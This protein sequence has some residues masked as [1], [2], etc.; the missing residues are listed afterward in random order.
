MYAPFGYVI[1]GMNIMEQL[2]PG[3]IITLTFVNEW[4]QLNLKRI[5]GKSFADAMN[6]DEDV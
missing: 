5:R 4:G 1:S 3:D 6:K 2:K